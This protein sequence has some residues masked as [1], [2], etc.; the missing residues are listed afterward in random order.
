M[1][2]SILCLM[3]TYNA[4]AR[5]PQEDLA[6]VAP[7]IATSFA[8]PGYVA[9]LIVAARLLQMLAVR[10]NVTK[11][12]E[13]AVTK[14]AQARRARTQMTVLT[15]KLASVAG[16]AHSRSS[17]TRIPIIGGAGNGSARAAQTHR[18]RYPAGVNNARQGTVSLKGIRPSRQMGP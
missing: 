5:S 6:K 14:Q 15:A 1:S 16:A 7:N 8:C 13:L 18:W 9:V 10:I 12:P 17:S 3:D 11:I 4:L 2:T